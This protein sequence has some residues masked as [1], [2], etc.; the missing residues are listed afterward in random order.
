MSG[1]QRQPR[2]RIV[3][4]ARCR[5]PFSRLTTVRYEVCLGCVTWARLTA[6]GFTSADPALALIAAYNASVPARFTTEKGQV[7]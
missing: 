4:C 3:T 7:A 6:A 2:T 5:A 1:F